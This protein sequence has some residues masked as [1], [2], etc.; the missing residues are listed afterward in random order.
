MEK[1]AGCQQSAQ[2]T[3]QDLDK[4]GLDTDRCREELYDAELSRSHV[5]GK[6]CGDRWVIVVKK[7]TVAAK[8][9]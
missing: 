9:V 7:L 2:A 6:R 1:D 5:Y 4:G 3:A 8:V